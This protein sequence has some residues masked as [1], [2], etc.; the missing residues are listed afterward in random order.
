[1]TDNRVNQMSIIAQLKDY[2]IVQNLLEKTYDAIQSLSEDLFLFLRLYVQNLLSKGEQVLSDRLIS[3]GFNIYRLADDTSFNVVPTDIQN[4]TLP[5]LL[6]GVADKDFMEKVAQQPSYLTTTAGFIRLIQSFANNQLIYAYMLRKSYYLAKYHQVFLSFAAKLFGNC[7]AEV[8]STYASPDWK[9]DKGKADLAV[10][11]AAF[12][13]YRYTFRLKFDYAILKATDIAYKLAS[14]AEFDSRVAINIA[15]KRFVKNYPPQDMI[16]MFKDN[17]L[18][19]SVPDTKTFIALLTK[20]CGA[21][22]IS[23]F[24]LSTPTKHETLSEVV[25]N[26]RIVRLIQEMQTN[27]RIA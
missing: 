24:I 26:Y 19:L 21:E 14:A 3:P 6:E 20:K 15:I 5:I 12:L 13:I 9:E 10:G 11:I 4:G 27:H 8:L 7:L 22:I 25:L 18:L 16:K 23:S 2:Q 1:M 17:G